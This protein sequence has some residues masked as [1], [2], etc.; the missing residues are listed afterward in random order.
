MIARL[1]IGIPDDLSWRAEHV[2]RSSHASCARAFASLA[3][4]V[5]TRHRGRGLWILPLM[6]ASTLPP[7]CPHEPCVAI[8]AA[9]A[10]TT[11]T[12]TVRTGRLS[13]K[14]RPACTP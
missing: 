2:V 13:A 7:D 10:T 8:A 14:L 3:W 11:A 6:T 1:L 12:T 9:T 4:T 5:A